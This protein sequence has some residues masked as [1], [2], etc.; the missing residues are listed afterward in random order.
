VL[1]GW[2]IS[3][4]GTF[5]DGFPLS[6]STLTNNTGSLGGGQRPNLKGDPHLANPT[7][8]KY[9]NTDAF[10]QPPGFTFGNV[11]RYMPNL[12]APGIRNFDTTI[13]KWWNFSERWR[14]QFRAAFFNAFNHPNFYAPNPTF[15]DPAFGTITQ[16]LPPRQIQLAIK[17][18]F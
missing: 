17:L 4:V 9:F 11:G 1:G 2:Q 15:G 14:L 12:R 6:I 18:Y 3:A 7:V 16:T 8:Q 13:A 10:E 5:K